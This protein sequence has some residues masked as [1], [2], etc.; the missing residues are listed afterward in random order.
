LLVL[1][2]LA[3]LSLDRL[4]LLVQLGSNILYRVN[5]SFLMS[6]GLSFLHVSF[7]PPQLVPYLMNRYLI[8]ILVVS[9]AK[10]GFGVLPQLLD[11]CS[12]LVIC[13]LPFLIRYFRIF[14]SV[15][16]SAAF[17]LLLGLLLAVCSVQQNL[18]FIAREFN[19]QKLYKDYEYMVTYFFSS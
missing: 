13:Y 9:V 17:L 6:F 2:E 16:A 1:P 4:D 12:D 10:I 14:L 15:R 3:G 7:V 19:V 5:D 8:D 11:E 18:F